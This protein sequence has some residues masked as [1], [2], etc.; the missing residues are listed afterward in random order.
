MLCNYCGKDVM[1]D[2]GHYNAID[3]N[4]IMCIGCYKKIVS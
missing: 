4:K 1:S 3:E 2:E